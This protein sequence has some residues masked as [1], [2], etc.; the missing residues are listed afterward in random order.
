MYKLELTEESEFYTVRTK[1]RDVIDSGDVIGELDEGLVYHNSN[2]ICYDEKVWR[3]PHHF[4][5][6]DVVVY[7]EPGEDIPIVEFTSNEELL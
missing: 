3:I 6:D 7:Y 2:R 1:Y 4:K 5:Y